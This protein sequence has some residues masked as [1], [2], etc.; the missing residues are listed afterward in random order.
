MTRLESWAPR[1]V[2]EER[3]AAEASPPCLVP[4]G[5]TV[6]EDAHA[7]RSDRAQTGTF[8][9]T[10]TSRQP[11]SSCRGR[12]YSEGPCTGVASRPRAWR[13]RRRRR[14][15]TWLARR[16]ERRR[17]RTWLVRWWRLEVAA[18]GR[19]E[20]PRA[21]LS[22]S[23]PGTRIRYARVSFFNA[24]VY[25]DKRCSALY[26]RGAPVGAKAPDGR[27]L[28]AHVDRL[29]SRRRGVPLRSCL[30]RCEVPFGM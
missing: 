18:F 16:R 13:A 8:C 25:N 29:L 10:G 4:L 5:R 14:R 20:P 15:R 23:V 26:C 12:S 6:W 19:K 3:R 7:A 11:Q 17:G 22:L 27:A 28:G 1:P 21:N 30:A 2:P 24:L 9:R